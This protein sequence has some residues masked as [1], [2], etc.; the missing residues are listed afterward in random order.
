MFWNWQHIFGSDSSALVATT[1]HY[2]IL[3]PI[4]EHYTKTYLNIKQL[5]NC[6]KLNYFFIS[7]KK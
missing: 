7:L 1:S 4:L 2:R 3:T 5:Q 6:T